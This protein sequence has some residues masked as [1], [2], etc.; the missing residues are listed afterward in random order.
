MYLLQMLCNADGTV[1]GVD[2]DKVSFFHK[3]MGVLLANREA[4]DVYVL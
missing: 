2:F 1:E 3:I 4:A